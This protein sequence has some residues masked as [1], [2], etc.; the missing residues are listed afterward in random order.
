MSLA[1]YW[2]SNLLFD[3]IMAY[4]PI[5]L[6][7][8]LMFVF[9]KQFEGVWILFML[10]PTAI[11]P[12]TYVT[13]FIFSSDINAQI[14]TLFIHFMSGGLLVIVVFVLQYIPKTMPIGDA[15]RWACCIFPNFCITH[16]I[17]FSASGSLLVTSRSIDETDDDP[18]IIIPRKI[19]VDIWALYNLKGDAY[20]LLLHFFLG[21]FLLMLI[22]LEVYSYFDWMPFCGFRHDS[23]QRRRQPHLAKD[24]DVIAEEK[25]VENQTND[26][27]NWNSISANRYDCIRVYNFQKEY[28]T[29]CGGPVKAVRNCSFGLDYGECFALLGVN[30]AG[31]STTFKSLTRDITPTTGEITVQ[32]YNIQTQFSEARNLIGYCPQRDALFP[33]LTVEETLKF[34]ALIKGIRTHKITPVIE[35]AIKQ[36]NLKDHRNKLAGTL[37]GGNKRKLSV[38]LALIGNPPI[39]LLDE[40]SAGMDPEARRFMWQVVEK[41]S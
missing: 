6:M 20:I 2:S 22:E 35:R 8:M 19:P 27:D 36:L 1:G 26:S 40:P 5:A 15:L 30:G 18:P 3:I 41:I 7:I 29:S 33:T 39:I 23:G 37:S 24:E 38:A 9:N 4:I 32:G 28:P 25:R 11:V 14:T 10:Y 21:M 16:G 31:K 12:F 13:S 17:L 34:Y